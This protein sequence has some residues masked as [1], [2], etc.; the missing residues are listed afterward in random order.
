M[1]KTISTLAVD[2]TVNTAKFTSEFVKAGK[3]AKTFESSLINTGKVVAGAVAAMG[4]SIATGMTVIANEMDQAG[5][6]AQ[7]LGLTT[8]A[9][10]SLRHAVEQTSEVTSGQ[11]DMALQRMTRRIAEAA[12][13]TGEAKDALKELNLDAGQLAQMSPD[14]V[15]KAIADQLSEVNSQSDRVRLAFKLFDSEGV[16]LVNTLQL[17]S[18]EIENLQQQAVDLGVAF[19]DKA[20]ASA[21]RFNDQL[22]VL[23]KTFTGTMTSLLTNSG[24][25]DAVNEHFGQLN[26]TLA[27]YRQTAREASDP[28]TA[29]YLELSKLEVE[30]KKLSE[31]ETGWFGGRK[32]ADQLDY[33]NKKIQETT[34]KVQT[35]LSK[36]QYLKML[37]SQTDEFGANPFEDVTAPYSYTKPEKEKKPAT[38]TSSALFDE[39]SAGFGDNPFATP[40]ATGDWSSML[41]DQT[42]LFDQ[43]ISNAQSQITTLESLYAEGLDRE[44]LFRDERLGIVQNALDQE[45]VSTERAAALK[46]QIEQDYQD[47]QVATASEGFGM[48]ANLMRTN[49]KEMFEIGKKA[50]IIQTTI[51]TYQMAVSSYKAL[52]GI[53]YIGPAL[54]VA[55][56][57]SAVAFGMS[58]VSAI[59]SQQFTPS[60]EGGFD[61][62]AGVNPVTQLHEKEMVLPKAQAEV[63]RDLAKGGGASPKVEVHNYSGANATTETLND[64]TVRVLIGAAVNAAES[65]IANGIASGKSPVAAAI[66]STYGIRR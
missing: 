4:A 5:K 10:T 43:D 57:A 32:T 9:L 48:I 12:Q 46:N 31:S 45:A 29:L 20:A 7:K 40:S 27:I 16:G 66:Q 54:G 52:A 6:T 47:A 15:F 64:G 53:S 23:K 13:G 19:D 2:L 41:Q 34:D 42:G 11:F 63:I 39:Q 24:A 35:L 50:A 49:N 25:L 18:A 62:P 44:R 28:V 1:S 59:S 17:G 56:A 3:R 58:Q 65:R 33:I 30:K 21:E 37:G 55:A 26:E 22:D 61:I 60:A 8:E 36:R 38:Y 14:Q 51:D